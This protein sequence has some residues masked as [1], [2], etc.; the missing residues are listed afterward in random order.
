MRVFALGVD[1]TLF[2]RHFVVVTEAVGVLRFPGKSRR[3]PH[4]VRRVR[5]FSALS[6][7]M[8][9]FILP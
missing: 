1:I 8:S 7:L 4:T 5:Y 6:G 3:F 9:Q 2:R